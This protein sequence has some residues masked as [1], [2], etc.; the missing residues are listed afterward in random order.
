M[1]VR[2]GDELPFHRP[3]PSRGLTLL[4]PELFQRHRGLEICQNMCCKKHLRK[5]A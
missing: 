2:D 5:P 1:L 4:R 3:C